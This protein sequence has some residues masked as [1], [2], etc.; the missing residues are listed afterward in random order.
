MRKHA[1]RR[2][3]ADERADSSSLAAEAYGIVRHR[4]LSGE[5]QLGQSLS[6]RTLAQ[7]LGMSFLPVTEALLRLEFEGLVESRPRAG[8]RVRIP[9][10]EDVF[11]Q[12]LVREALEVQAAV[13]FTKAATEAERTEL[14]KLAERVDLMSSRTDRGLYVQLHHKLHKR[15]AESTHCRALIDVIEKTHALASTWH[16][17]SRRTDPANPPSWHQHLIAE[18]SSGD[19]ARA[20]HAVREHIALGRDYV[21]Q[22]L[23][24]YFKIRDEHGSTFARGDRSVSAHASPHVARAGDGGRRRS[25]AS[26]SSGSH[27]PAARRRRLN[28]TAAKV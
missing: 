3:G 13:L 27:T 6:R 15:I 4:I 8:T 24:P 12:Y 19:S 10:R 21:L 20:V 11:G 25:K 5:L 26:V 1:R 22:Q 28:Q 23:E 14:R 7:E 9:S 18:L 16:G 17:F 2:I